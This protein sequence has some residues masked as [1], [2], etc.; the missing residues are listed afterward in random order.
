MVCYGVLFIRTNYCVVV[1][2]SPTE[3]LQ[4]H[5]SINILNSIT[6]IKDNVKTTSL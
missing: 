6:V 5:M 2:P 3:V 4:V 1:L